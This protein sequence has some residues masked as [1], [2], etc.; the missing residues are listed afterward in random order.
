MFLNNVSLGVYGHAV[1]R[2]AYRDAKLRTLVETADEV[3][4][5]SAE[6]P[7]PSAFSTTWDASTAIPP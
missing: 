7:A 5:S 6:A 4:A 1:Q 3:L 2:S